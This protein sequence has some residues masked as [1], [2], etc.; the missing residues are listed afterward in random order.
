[1]AKVEPGRG[2]PAKSHSKRTG[3]SGVSEGLARLVAEIIA[4]DRDNLTVILE[5]IGAERLGAAA[6]K[7]AKARWLYVVGL[8]SQY[9][10]AFYVQYACRMLKSPA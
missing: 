6:A 9:P 4:T 8:R 2:P 5:A 1:M 10:A 3:A 7:L